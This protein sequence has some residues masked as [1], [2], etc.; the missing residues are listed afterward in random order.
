MFVERARSKTMDEALNK[1]PIS[2]KYERGTGKCLEIKYANLTGDELAKPFL[3][4]YEEYKRRNGSD[5]NEKIQ[6][7][8][9]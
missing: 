3:R 6:N 4:G 1:I 8:A 7:P 2:I 5:K 9:I